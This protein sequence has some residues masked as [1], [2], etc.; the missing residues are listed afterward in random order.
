MQADATDMETQVPGAASSSLTQFDNRESAEIDSFMGELNFCLGPSDSVLSGPSL[1]KDLNTATNKIV[2]NLLILNSPED[3]EPA[4]RDALKI[5]ADFDAQHSESP[6]YPAAKAYLSCVRQL[7]IE[8][9]P[10][11][12]TLDAL[13]EVY[14]P[15]FRRVAGALS[16]FGCTITPGDDSAGRIRPVD[17][18]ICLSILDYAVPAREQEGTTPTRALNTLVNRVVRTVCVG[19]DEDLQALAREMESK[20]NKF[21]TKCF[22]K[23]SWQGTQE[24]MFYHALVNLVKNGLTDEGV[25]ALSGAYLNSYQ[26]LM[27][28]LVQEVG[29]RS[30]PASEMVLKSF[31]AWEREIRKELT[32]PAWKSRPSDLVGSWA[33][34]TSGWD[35]LTDLPVDSSAAGGGTTDGM[36]DLGLSDLVV[37]F[38][39]DGTVQI[40]VEKG[41]GLQWRVEPGPTHL[42]TIYF[43]MIPA[44]PKVKASSKAGA[45]GATTLSYTGYVDRGAR[46]EA[47]FSKRFLKMTGRMT[48]VERGQERPSTRFAMRLVA[49]GEG[50]GLLE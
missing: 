18:D 36:V 9:C 30:T 21:M 42:D 8:G 6:Q 10:A 25:P 5:E 28:I 50:I 19:S 40:P 7:A 16:D 22:G 31:L 1:L 26:R 41:V 3:S 14:K 13:S 46:I 32:E 20:H 23:G 24:D 48:S 11:V 12:E 45:G 17:K 47:R 29:T 39:K 34:N 44:A 27:G 43:E 38:R 49:R 15:A 35:G 4:M 33:L 2:K 37:S